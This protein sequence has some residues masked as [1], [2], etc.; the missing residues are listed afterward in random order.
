MPH[1][2]N[3]FTSHHLTPE[4]TRKNIIPIEPI[5]QK[6]NYDYE[7]VRNYDVVVYEDVLDLS[8]KL[9]SVIR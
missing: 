2:S 9:K 4:K 5:P 6:P 3:E 8:T 7:L 1:R